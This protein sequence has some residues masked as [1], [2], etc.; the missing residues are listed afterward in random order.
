MAA[1]TSPR[2]GSTR[3]RPKRPAPKRRRAARLLPRDAADPPLRGE[4][5]PALRH[6]PDRRLLPSLYRPGGGRG[7]HPARAAAGR[8][9][10]HRLPRPRPHA[11]LQHG[12]A[13]G[14]GRADRAQHAA[15]RRAR[16]A[17]CTCSPARKASMAG[18]ASSAARCR[19][20]PASPSPTSTARTAA[21]ASPTWATAPSTRARST[22]AST[23]RRCGSCRSST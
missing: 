19:S 8:Q 9:R 2:S 11:G 15:T 17:R 7:R 18:T 12:P 5:R 13:P 4:G 10:H 23:W 21:S 3:R 1:R 14:H 20:A 6:G 22:R 16:A